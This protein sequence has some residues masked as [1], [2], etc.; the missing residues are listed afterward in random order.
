VL[1]LSIIVSYFI[2]IFRLSIHYIH[3]KPIVKANTKVYPLLLLH[4]W[5]G[6][7]REFYDI[8]PM[9]TTPTKD[10]IA[11]EVI[12][13]SLPGYG[14][15]QGASKQGLGFLKMAII[16]RNLMTRIGHEKFYVQGGDWGSVIGSSIAS[17]FP[18][19]T[20]GYHSNMCGIQTPLAFIKTFAASFYPTFFIEDE[21][22][23][24]WIFPFSK[25][26]FYLLQESGYMHIQSTKPDTIGHALLNN[27]VGLA[28]YIIEKFSTW[29][30]RDYRQLADGGIEKYFTLDSLLDNVMI[31]YLTDSITTSVRLYKESFGGGFQD[32]I[33]R[34][35]ITSPSG[36]AHYKHELIHQAPFV[37]KERLVNLVHTSTFDDGGHFASMQLPKVMYEDF[38]TFVRKSM[39]QTTTKTTN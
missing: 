4:G 17:L 37:Y 10:N 23:A 16:M 1:I 33:E 3:V 28:A 6:S 36:C 31:Y 24:N 32:E 27:P 34:V 14:F 19:N 35:P 21:K 25:N 18:E 20:L 11:F 9:L 7:V 15:S 5:P 8:I 30:N 2:N 38:V 39:K 22:L 12:A 29:T 26:F 13:P